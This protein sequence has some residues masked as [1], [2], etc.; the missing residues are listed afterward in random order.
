MQFNPVQCHLEPR[1]LFVMEMWGMWLQAECCRVSKGRL[2]DNQQS[3]HV[4]FCKSSRLEHTSTSRLW[5]SRVGLAYVH[6]LLYWSAADA[7]LRCVFWTQ[8]DLKKVL[9]TPSRHK[10]ALVPTSD[11]TRAN[12]IKLAATVKILASKESK[13]RL[14]KSMWD[15]RGSRE[16]LH[17]AMFCF[18]CFFNSVSAVFC[19]EAPEMFCAQL[20]FTRLS[21]SMGSS[22]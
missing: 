17:E 12:A 9:F 3:L 14:L 2:A 15:L 20:N 7:F 21:I 5:S 8:T 18:F 19:F 10:G 16:K 11:G 6:Y 13:Q 4:G 1:L 22:R